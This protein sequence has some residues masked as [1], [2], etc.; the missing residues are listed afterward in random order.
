MQGDEI[1]TYSSSC[2]RL[3]GWKKPWAPI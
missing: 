2:L 1:S 3:Q